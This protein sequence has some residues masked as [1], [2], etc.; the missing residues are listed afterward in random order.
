MNKGFNPQ[1]TVVTIKGHLMQNWVCQTCGMIDEDTGF[2]DGCKYPFKECQK[3]CA[4]QFLTSCKECD[5][6]K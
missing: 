1:V 3:D 4:C 5:C 6:H 2:N